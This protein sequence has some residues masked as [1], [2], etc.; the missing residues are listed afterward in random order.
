[1][2]YQ[3]LSSAIRVCNLSL[4]GGILTLPSLLLVEGGGVEGNLSSL[5]TPF[6]KMLLLSADL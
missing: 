6:N 1:M 2:V 3:Q 4:E 5:P